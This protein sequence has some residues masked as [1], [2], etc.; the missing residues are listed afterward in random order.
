VHVYGAW[1]DGGAPGLDCMTSCSGMS[2]VGV[3]TLVDVEP[4]P[5]WHLA[6]LEGVECDPNGQCIL[7]VTGDSLIRA[8]FAM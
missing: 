5:G 8:V 6:T 4:S 1:L 7:Y 3:T 2:E